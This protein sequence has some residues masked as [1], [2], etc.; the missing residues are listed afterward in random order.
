MGVYIEIRPRNRQHLVP[1]RR[2]HE[3]LARI[4][5]LRQIRN[6]AETIES[7]DRVLGRISM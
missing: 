3:P 7:A 1:K 6:I 5:R 4:E 2:E